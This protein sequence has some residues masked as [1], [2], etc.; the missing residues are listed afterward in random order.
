MDKKGAPKGPF[1]KFILVDLFIILIALSL[2]FLLYFR[3]FRTE[4]LNVYYVLILPIFLIRIGVLFLFRLYDFSRGMTSFDLVYYT[5]C[6]MLIAHGIEIFV[7]LYTETYIETSEL[8]SKVLVQPTEASFEIS[9]YILFLNFLFSWSGAAAWRV[10]Y[11]RRRRRWAYDRTRILIVGAGELGESV[12]REI[13][14]YSRLGHEVVGLIDDD[15][16]SRSNGAPIIGRMSDLP[17]LVQKKQIQ[18]IIVTSRQANR[19]ELLHIIST[20]QATGC[21]VRLLPEL[22]EVIIGHV[23]IGQVAGIPLITLDSEKNNEWGAF[24]KRI[25]DVIASAVSLIL[26]LPLFILIAIAIKL[27]S[28]GPIFYRQKRVGKDSAPFTLFKFR[29][30]FTNAETESGPV[31][32]WD[33]DPRVTSIGRFLRKWHLDETPQFYNVLK[34]EMSLVGPRPERPHFAEQHKNEIPAY[35][36]RETVRPGMTGLAQIHGFYNSPVEHKLRYD[37][38]YINNISFLLDLK[39]LFLTL[40]VTF[41]GHGSRI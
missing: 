24:F 19:Q 27:T 37:L 38:A 3:D 10:L 5:G 15:I 4:N 28:E 31:L 9:R 6:A 11:L 18:E 36:M 33:N 26:L 17:D 21:K 40:R 30:M 41:S 2:A 22:Y 14:Q 34:G 16:E 12:Q 7:I 32:S 35:L 29:T 1:V 8:L 13:Q 25:F 20:C 23:E 39:I